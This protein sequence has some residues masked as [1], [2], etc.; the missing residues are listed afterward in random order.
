MAGAAR[1]L[2]PDGLEGPGRAIDAPT[3]CSVVHG[4][5]NGAP[6]PPIL[7][8]ALTGGQATRIGV[9]ARD[10]A[11]RPGE[12]QPGA[13]PLREERTRV[14]PRRRSPE[15]HTVP[16]SGPA[17]VNV[18]KNAA[19]RVWHARS[20]G[21]DARVEDPRVQRDEANQAKNRTTGGEPDARLHEQHQPR[22]LPAIPPWT[23]KVS[24]HP[25]G[26]SAIASSPQ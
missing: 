3:G 9:L 5:M 20:L 22:G 7:P 4:H 1:E 6:T 17:F 14:A 10:R 19:V 11:R 24:S 8:Q 12:Q 15:A 13:H 26:T 25:A 23:S 16:V 18:Q 21:D 2:A